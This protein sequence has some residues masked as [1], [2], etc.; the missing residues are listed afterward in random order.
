[1][2]RNIENVLPSA[3]SEEERRRR[4]EAVNYAT[5]S[6]RLEG[7]V[8]SEEEE[9]HAERFING[10]IDLAEFVKVRHDPLSSR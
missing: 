6:V 8:M 5:A 10:E 1:M 9:R 2:T 4:Q 3:I 7:F